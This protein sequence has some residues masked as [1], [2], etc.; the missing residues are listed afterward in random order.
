MLGWLTDPF[1]HHRRASR[2]DVEVVQVG[3]WDH[4]RDKTAPADFGGPL[5]AFLDA[6]VASA[7]AGPRPPPTLVFATMPR[8][9]EALDASG[10][11]AYERSLARALSPAPLFLNRVASHLDLKRD[12][13]ARCECLDREDYHPA[14]LQNLW[15]AQRL[16]N[17]AF[18][19]AANAT[20]PPPSARVALRPPG[21]ASCCCAPP[22]TA[23]AVGM[24]AHWARVCVPAD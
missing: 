1:K 23:S 16:L 11:G 19:S 17:L 13:A 8:S 20:D 7:A 18:P 2:P 12:L 9:F 4:A 6:W 5:R 15:D 14:H 22:A 24:I 3:S 10:D 21:F